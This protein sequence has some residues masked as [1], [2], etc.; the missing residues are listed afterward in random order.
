MTKS[1]TT[2]FLFLSVLLLGGFIF[3]FERRADSTADRLEQARRALSIEP[4]RVSALRIVTTNYTVA[5][6]LEADGWM[7]REPASARG[8]EGQINRVLQHLADLPRGEIIT[9]EER[10]EERLT[11]EDYGLVEPVAEITMTEGEL[12]RTLFLG[13]SAPV[14]GAYYLMESNSTDVVAAEAPIW[15]ILP[16]EPADLRSRRL[17]Y[18][19]PH[20]VQRVDV[21]R[22]LGFLQL[23]RDAEG[24]WSIEQPVAARADD[25]VVGD[26]LNKF[27]RVEIQQF[28]TDGVEDL[29]P[30]D[31]AEPGVEISLWTTDE[32]E[33][34]VVRLGGP[35]EDDSELVHATSSDGESVVA[36]GRHALFEAGVEPDLLRDRDLV[37]LDPQRI[38]FIRI[39]EGEHALEFMKDD[40]GSWSVTKP[41]SRKAFDPLVWAMVDDW[42]QATVVS[43]VADGVTNA[44]AL[45]LDPPP[46]EI[47]FAS[48]PI[49]NGTAAEES[50]SAPDP[51][52]L[53]RLGVVR[54]EDGAVHV[55]VNEGDAIYEVSPETLGRVRADPLVYYDRTVL[56]LLPED[57]RS[58]TI[59]NGRRQS[60]VRDEEG[61]FICGPEQPGVVM[62]A[63][64]T[65]ILT[66][67]SNLRAALF[68]EENPESLEAYGLDQ[69]AATLTLGL[70]GEA[71]ISK[72]LLFG[73]E[74]EKGVFAMIRGQDTVFIVSQALRDRLLSDLCVAVSAGE[75]EPLGADPSPAP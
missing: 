36:V 37:D 74:I 60:V 23:T 4:D 54:R 29:A 48:E 72:A 51:E 65:N 63:V 33:P 64:V 6:T 42:S 57:V 53:V 2:L 55:R 13:G 5:C 15:D 59:E 28:V 30:Y 70:T 19:E 34:L 75:E 69:P 9:E 1:R 17:V 50:T 8:D 12:T 49:P 52:M 11:L 44:S 43:F 56:S 62:G 45:G 66:E 40:A 25:A 16:R 47:I 32:D 73:G 71:G 68:A 18:L 39:R 61:A 3:F 58:I 10:R 21:R 24:R 20:E 22:P 27:C 14:G 31:L 7:L 35:L 38:A 41:R 26:L 67:T 46:M